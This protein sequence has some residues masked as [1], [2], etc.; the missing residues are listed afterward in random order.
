MNQ[1]INRIVCAS[2]QASFGKKLSI[3]FVRGFRVSAQNMVIA[4]SWT[5]FEI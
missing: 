1:L 3:G 4:V 5:L 2:Q